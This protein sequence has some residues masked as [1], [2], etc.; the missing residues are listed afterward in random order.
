LTIASTLSVVMSA[1]T[2]RSM[3][4]M[5]SLSIEIEKM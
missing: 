5:G 1:C 3:D 2:A 4:G